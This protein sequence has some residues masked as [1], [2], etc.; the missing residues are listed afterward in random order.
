MWEPAPRR[1]IMMHE[2]GGNPRAQNAHSTAFGAFQMLE[3]TRKQYLGASWRSTS[4][5][6]QYAAATRYVDQRYGSWHHAR[7]FWQAHHWY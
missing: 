7:Q 4:L 6:A 1:W 5:G 2:S 3:A